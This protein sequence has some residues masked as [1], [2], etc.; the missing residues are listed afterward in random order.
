MVR[1]C[2]WPMTLQSKRADACC[3]GRA[4]GMDAILLPAPHLILL[5]VGEKQ[6][7]SCYRPLPQPSTACCCFIIEKSCCD[8]LRGTQCGKTECIYLSTLG[9]VIP[10]QF[11]FGITAE[12]NNKTVSG[13]G[14]RM[15][16]STGTDTLANPLL[17]PVASFQVLLWRMKFEA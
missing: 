15:P 10:G 9:L 8:R 7:V 14:I 6:F 2:G 17:F 11:G 16:E 5:F 4:C 3:V 12:Q 1:K 13:S